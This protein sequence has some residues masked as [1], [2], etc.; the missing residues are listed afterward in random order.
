VRVPTSAAPLVTLHVWRVPAVQVGRAL[1]RVAADRRAL[2]SVHGLRFARLVGTGRGL[3]VR[4]V[5][6]RRWALV[7][8]WSRAEDAAAFEHSPVVRRW[9]A[10]SDEAFRAE[11]RPVSSTGRWGGTEPFGDPER[12]PCPGS[13]A[14]LTRSH[15]RPR[16]LVRFWRAA[17]PV[18]RELAEAPGM[19]FAMGFGE[20]P[21]LLAGTFSLW[22]DEASLRAF[23]Y[24]PTRHRDVVARTPAEGWFGEQLF[25]RFAVL[26]TEGTLDGVALD[27]PVTTTA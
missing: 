9:R 18:A 13:V 25:T 10:L 4:S 6:L 14:A 17:P 11:L 3:T 22:S 20:L 27:D 15:L 8:S 26:R 23:A 5:D 21:V 7:A 16:R 19:R 24:G 1:V 12:S 2:R